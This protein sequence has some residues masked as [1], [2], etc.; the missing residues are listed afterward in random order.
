MKDLL[1][2]LEARKTPIESFVKTWTEE[3]SR[4]WVGKFRRNTLE[5]S[6]AID[7]HVDDVVE[8]VRDYIA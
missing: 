5:M 3:Q 1:A 6:I 2:I 4:E 8:A 7:K